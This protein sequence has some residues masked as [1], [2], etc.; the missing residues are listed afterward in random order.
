[1]NRTELIKEVAKANGVTQSEAES[2]IIAVLTAI[3]TGVEKDGET[4]IIG[5][6]SFKSTTRAA[7]EGR[8]PA[9]GAVIQIPEKNVV[10]FKPYF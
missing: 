8:N 7:R 9:T 4:K 3:K 5:F 2:A 10:K 1:M 6:G